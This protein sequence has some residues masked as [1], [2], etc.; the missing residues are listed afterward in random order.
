MI[1]QKAG[2]ADT[3]LLW[4]APCSG[5]LQIKIPARPQEVGLKNE[6]RS[7]Q[8]RPEALKQLK[9]RPDVVMGSKGVDFV[10]SCSSSTSASHS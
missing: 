10:I 2:K 1:A 4:V 9:L 8:G 5:I 7:V 3:S 6:Q